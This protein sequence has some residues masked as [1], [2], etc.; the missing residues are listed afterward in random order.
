MA[1]TAAVMAAA[2]AIP[3]AASTGHARQAES[4][5]WDTA[6]PRPDPFRYLPRLT[7]FRLSST[8]ITSGRPLP[9][10]QWAPLAGRPGAKGI[11]PQLSWSGAPARAKSYVVTMY[12]PESPILGGA[13]HRAVVNIPGG[14][15][16]LPADAGRPHSPF[17]P[18][19]AAE[20]PASA[21]PGGYVGASPEP[22]TGP[23]DYYLTVWAL[24]VPRFKLTG[25]T[26]PALM[27]FALFQHAIARASIIC[28]TSAGG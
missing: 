9:V 1:G 10:A 19:L 14:R 8:S 20:I 22:G 25:N 21:G 7:S 6:P 15:R 2:V 16:S 5:R 23:H 17:L 13:L 27:N 3:A 12:D 24:D 18:R 4:P 11:S 28:P 26:R